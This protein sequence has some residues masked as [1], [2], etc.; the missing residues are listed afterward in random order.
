MCPF[1]LCGPLPS[2]DTHLLLFPVLQLTFQNHW[3]TLSFGNMLY[4][5]FCVG[6]Q[7][8]VLPRPEHD[9]FRSFPLCPGTS[10]ISLLSASSVY[11]FLLHFL[12]IE[13]YKSLLG[14]ESHRRK[15]NIFGKFSK[16]RWYPFP[17]K[18]RSKETLGIGDR[19]KRQS[20]PTMEERQSLQ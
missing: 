2:L 13:D 6:W 12:S 1:R 3:T 8:H 4:S 17:Q 5:A 16:V 9:L 14:E 15:Q 11:I 19:G 7:I 20:F 18:N 10:D